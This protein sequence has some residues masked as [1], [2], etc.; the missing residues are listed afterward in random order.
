MPEE[1]K[2]SMAEWEAHQSAARV[3]DRRE[4]LFHIMRAGCA[5]LRPTGGDPYQFNCKADARDAIRLCT[6]GP[7]VVGEWII[8]ELDP[9]TG[10]EISWT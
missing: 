7:M 4:G 2:W 10:K 3:E 9:D 1:R 5:Y 8:V 6:D